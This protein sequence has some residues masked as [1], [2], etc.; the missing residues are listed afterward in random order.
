MVTTIKVGLESILE[1]P[2]MVASWRGGGLIVDFSVIV[3]GSVN[4][5]LASKAVDFQVPRELQP[6]LDRFKG[7]YNNS[8]R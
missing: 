2:L 3:G 1:F 7:Y 5:P 6:M 4:W 8:H